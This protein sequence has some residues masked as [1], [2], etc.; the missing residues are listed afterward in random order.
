[1]FGLR[2]PGS[3]PVFGFKSNLVLTVSISIKPKDEKFYIPP[4]KRNL[5]EKAYFARLDKGKSSDVDADVSKPK[6]K[7]TVKEHNK[8]N[9]KF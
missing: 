3:V 4:F 2:E 7:P 6:S 5:K 9:R 8:S 1:M